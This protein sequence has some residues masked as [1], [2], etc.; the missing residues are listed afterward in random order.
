MPVW[1]PG[2]MMGEKREETV[3][4]T[5][6]VGTLGSMQG[7]K[8]LNEIVVVFSQLKGPSLDRLYKPQKWSFHL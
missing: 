1:I 3:P 7:H 5:G 6:A 8:V 2:T 4:T